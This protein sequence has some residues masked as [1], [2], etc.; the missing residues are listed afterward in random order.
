MDPSP[1]TARIITRKK[2]QYCRFADTNQWHLFDSIFLPDATFVFVDSQGAVI[3]EGGVDYSFSS[4]EQ[5]TAHFREAFKVLQTIHIISPGELE[6]TGPDEV[7]AVWGLIY[8]AGPKGTEDGPHGTGGGHY[9]ETWKRKGDD[10]FIQTLRME[11][12]YWTTLGS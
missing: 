3:N 12:L 10:W 8:H 5:W 11:R 4:T 9:H 1:E 2:L 7:K 6:Q